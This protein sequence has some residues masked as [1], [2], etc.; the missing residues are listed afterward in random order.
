M[1]VNQ[2]KEQFK[3]NFE[4]QYDVSLQIMGTGRQNTVYMTSKETQ[5]ACK[6]LLE[7]E[8]VMKSLPQNCVDLM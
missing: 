8:I 7:S 2:N 1:L 4:F 6:I 3:E 5:Q